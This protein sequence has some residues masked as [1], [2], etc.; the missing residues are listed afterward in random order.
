MS[1]TSYHSRLD[2]RSLM[3]EMRVWDGSSKVNLDLETDLIDGT[4]RLY[5]QITMRMGLISFMPDEGTFVAI[6][7][8][9]VWPAGR[10]YFFLY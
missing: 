5:L 3:V 8:P 1:A 9:N 6:I 2:T 7:L 4:T 10:Q